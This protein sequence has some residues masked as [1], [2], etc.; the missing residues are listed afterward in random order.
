MSKLIYLHT[1]IEQFG[2]PYTK[3]MMLVFHSSYFT[4]CHLF[5]VYI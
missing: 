3:E 5:H 2:N 1:E 4:L